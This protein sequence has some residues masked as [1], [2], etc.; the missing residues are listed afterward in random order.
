MPAVQW[1]GQSLR[2][3]DNSQSNTSR[4][5][6]LYRERH[7]DKFILKSVLG[8]AILVDLPGVFM[9]DMRDIGGVLHA[10]TGG[11]VYRIT[12]GDGETGLFGALGGEWYPIASGGLS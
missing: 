4:L 2:D 6:N 5:L 1:V 10:V 12:G 9:R 7:G 8:T 11:K 3:D